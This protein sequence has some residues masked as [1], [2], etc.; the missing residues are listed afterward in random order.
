MAATFDWNRLSTTDK[1][2]SVTALLALISLFLPWF[3]VSSGPFSVSVGGFSSYGWL[4]A[5]LI[6][7]AG[8]YIV[9][10]RAGTDMPKFSYGPGVI[11]LGLSALGALIVILRWATIPRASYGGGYYNYGPRVG[12]YLAL[13]AGIV[14][15]LFA[16][17]MFRASGE[18]VPW[19]K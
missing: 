17:R 11:V 3:G 7:A 19:K 1:V 10:L 9:L 4:G 2:I 16:L 18:A 15:A 5:L 6:V 14:Q 12:L 13:I 8:V